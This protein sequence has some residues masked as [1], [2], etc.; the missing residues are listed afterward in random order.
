MH[1][2]SR[3]PERHISSAEQVGRDVFTF[4]RKLYCQILERFRGNGTAALITDGWQANKYH[5]YA[6]LL[7]PSYTDPP[8]FLCQHGTACDSGESQDAS[9]LAAALFQ[10]LTDLDRFNIHPQVLTT[11]NASVMAAAVEDLNQTIMRSMAAGE[12]SL[13]PLQRFPCVCHTLSLVVQDYLKAPREQENGKTGHSLPQMLAH[14]TKNCLCNEIYL[15]AYTPTRWGTILA[16]LKSLL[17]QAR[18]E[19]GK[20]LVAPEDISFLTESIQLLEVLSKTIHELEGNTNS[21]I[22][23]T[24]A[25]PQIRQ[26]ISA[27]PYSL[28]KETMLRAFDSRFGGDPT[29]RNGLP[30]I[31]S[32]DPL[33]VS[34]SGLATER[35][36]NYGVRSSTMGLAV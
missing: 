23:A 22:D 4:S 26:T 7:K 12:T 31:I 32:T 8:I 11:D 27:V 21:I 18:K 30:L 3:M 25:I 2:I 13:R 29:E 19:P 33:P 10:I 36:L 6:F 17:R 14:W 1:W 9:W 28:H 20:N 5:V 15:P 35:I 24:R 16:T 34:S